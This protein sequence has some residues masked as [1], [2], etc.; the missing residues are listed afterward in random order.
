MKWM[1]KNR[2]KVWCDIFSRAP[3]TALVTLALTRFSL[4]DPSLSTAQLTRPV[5]GY[6]SENI[7]RD[8]PILKDKLKHIAHKLFKANTNLAQLHRRTQ[9]CTNTYVFIQYAHPSFTHL[10]GLLVHF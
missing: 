4:C 8:I 7:H 1:R 6:T 2:R 10:T 9:A 3:Y 5:V